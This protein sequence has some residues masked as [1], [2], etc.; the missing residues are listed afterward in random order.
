MSVL[1]CDVTIDTYIVMQD[2]A[3]N[4]GK[5]CCWFFTKANH[6]FSSENIVFM[7]HLELYIF[8]RRKAFA[9]LPFKTSILKSQKET[10]D[11]D[12]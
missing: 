12:T 2:W 1:H 7:A 5:P 4:K 6:K 10:I 9:F 3:K 11:E 8:Y